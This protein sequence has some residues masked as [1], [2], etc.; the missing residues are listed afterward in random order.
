MADNTAW[1]GFIV[2]SDGR[3][4]PASHF[5]LVDGNLA[6]QP[7]LADAVRQALEHAG[8]VNATRP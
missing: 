1:R 4:I 2:S 7:D 6:M 3:L 8:L 5:N